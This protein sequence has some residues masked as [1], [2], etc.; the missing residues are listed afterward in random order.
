MKIVDEI[1]VNALDR[2][3]HNNTAEVFYNVKKIHIDIGDDGWISIMNDGDGLG[4]H[5]REVGYS[6]PSV[7]IRS[8]VDIY[9]LRRQS[10]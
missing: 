10:G 8:D 1:L 5:P 3:A 9:Q 7:G 6:Y 4:S 2:V